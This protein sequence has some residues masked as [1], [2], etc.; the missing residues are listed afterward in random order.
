M[1][2]ETVMDEVSILKFFETGPIE[3]VE[4][5]YNIVCA[6]MR[7]RLSGRGEDRGESAEPGP[8]RKR[9]A[10]TNAETPQEEPAPTKV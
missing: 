7:D 10:R 3:K 6:K 2:K 5:V 4:V 8:V 9:Q 1:A